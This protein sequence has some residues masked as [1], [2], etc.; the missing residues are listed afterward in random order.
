MILRSRTVSLLALGAICLTGCTSEE[1]PAQPALKPLALKEQ[2]WS[3]VKSAD[4]YVVSWAGVLSNANPWHFGEHVVATIVGHDA[5]GAEV[6]R[7]PQ[8]LD[9]VSPGGQLAFAGQRNVPR[10]PAKVAIE[11]R[12]VKWRLAGR[13]PSA[14]HKFPVS[15]VQTLPQKDG[16]YVVKGF[17]DNPYTLPVGTLVV[18]AL[19]RDKS[20]KLVGGGSTF[21]D[22]VRTGRPP[23]FV[24]TVSGLPKSAK[25]AT[26]EVTART[27]GSTGKP[28]EE[29]ALAGIAPV[30]T[31]KPTTEPFTEDRSTQ[32]ISEYK[33]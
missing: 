4:G 22:D 20:G 29:L 3:S 33:Q 21:V 15:R 30:H 24:L 5:K 31:A 23:R 16:S 32:L 26:T 19:L 17:V 2:A 1:Q 8:P 25:V 11:Y 18:N 7:F 13:I 6:I 14:F 28:Y 10:K 27:W 12:T 9:A